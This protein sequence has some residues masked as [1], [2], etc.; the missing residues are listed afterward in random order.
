MTFKFFCAFSAL[1]T[2][3][4][5]VCISTS[6]SAPFHAHPSSDYTLD[7]SISILLF[8]VQKYSSIKLAFL[9]PLIPQ[10]SFQKSLSIPLKSSIYI[11]SFQ[12]IIFSPFL[13]NSPFSKPNFLT[14]STK[15]PPKSFLNISSSISLF[16]KACFFPF[17]P[18][19]CAEM[20]AA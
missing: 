7:P 11:N 18:G 3:P 6:P 9:F 13:Y 8:P 1:P 20:N 12:N 17:S 10:L 19:K 15:F 4:I 2:I 5:L 14:P 16:H